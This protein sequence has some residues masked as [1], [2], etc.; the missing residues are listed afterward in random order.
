MGLTNVMS[1]TLTNTLSSITSLVWLNIVFAIIS[2]T[3]NIIT[4][5]L[6]VLELKSVCKSKSYDAKGVFVPFVKRVFFVCDMKNKWLFSSKL[7]SYNAVKF[8]KLSFFVTRHPEKIITTTSEVCFKAN[9]HNTVWNVTHNLCVT[10]LNLFRI[11]PWQGKRSKIHFKC[12]TFCVVK[13]PMKK[14][15]Y[16]SL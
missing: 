16:N 3:T 1:H 13:S 10:S 11:S 4:S 9:S 5:L 12:N 6:H 7:V 15:K 8:F 2:T 14:R